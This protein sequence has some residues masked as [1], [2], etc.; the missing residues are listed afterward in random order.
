MDGALPAAVSHYYDIAQLNEVDLG[1][2]G[3]L[4][5]R[6]AA[7]AAIERLAVGSPLV[8]Q[9]NGEKYTLH[10]AD[11]QHVGTMA[12]NYRPPANG[13]FLHACVYAMHTRWRSD[14]VPPY[15]L[16]VKVDQWYVV[17]PEIVFSV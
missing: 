3:R 16:H 12:K 14:A 9:L 7:H 2:A 5:D 10:D 4:H 6:D 13:I 17:V 15:D 11:G 8:L 1:F